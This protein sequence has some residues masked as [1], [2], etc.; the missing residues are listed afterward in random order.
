MGS[1]VVQR[2]DDEIDEV[3]NLAHDP[4]GHGGTV[5]RRTIFEQGVAQG[6]EW[7]CGLGHGQPPLP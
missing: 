7:A 5:Y 4:G 2:T 3:L 6:T 1:Y